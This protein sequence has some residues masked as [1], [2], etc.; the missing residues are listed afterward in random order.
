M[1]RVKICG[2]TNLDDALAS[3]EA[4]CDALGF[5]FYKKSPRYIK[6]EKVS[7]IIMHLPPHILKVGVFV[8]AKEKNIRSI[9]QLCSLDMLQFHG[10]ESLR[11]CE[12]FG[13]YKIVK[14]FRVRKRMDFK[15]ILDYKT[16]AYLFDT[17]MK[18]KAGGTGRSF[19]WALIRHLGGFH[20]PI[21]L[22]GGLNA[23]N[24][25]EAIKKVEPDWVDASTSVE[26]C[27][28]KKDHKK[29]KEF[30]KIAKRG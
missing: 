22:S 25:G 6:P 4:G 15:N 13:D 1:V 30:I 18:S 20:K 10:E 27:P 11:F 7:A 17:F 14:A 19:N 9:A 29:V 12:R 23:E 5:V 16:F 2:I 3:I 28:G 26:L 21:F 8:N 24:V